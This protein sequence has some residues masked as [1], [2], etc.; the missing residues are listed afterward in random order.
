[1]VRSNH[2]SEMFHIATLLLH[3]LEHEVGDLQPLPQVFQLQLHGSIGMSAQLQLLQEFRVLL[4]GLLTQIAA[5]TCM[6]NQQLF[7]SS[8]QKMV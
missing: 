6:H 8:K 4:L 2:L 7:I 3:L 5:N 1:M